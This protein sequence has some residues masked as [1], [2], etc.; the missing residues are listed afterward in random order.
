MLQP[1]VTAIRQP[2]E[3]MGKTAADVLFARLK[4]NADDWP[5][6]STRTTLKVELILRPSCGCES[7]ST[8]GANG[9]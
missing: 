2:V 1:P 8:D 5:K 9:T 7:V 3:A 4:M 6:A